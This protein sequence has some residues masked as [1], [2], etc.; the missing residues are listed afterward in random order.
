M[1]DVTGRIGRYNTDGSIAE[2]PR[3]DIG[4][5]DYDR[6]AGAIQGISAGEFVIL[7]PGYVDDGTLAAMRPQN[8]PKAPSKSKKDVVADD[9]TG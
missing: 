7:P 2:W 5:H 1:D 8:A 4:G 3:Y 9:T 6:M